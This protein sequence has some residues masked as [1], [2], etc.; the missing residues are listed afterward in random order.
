MLSFLVFLFI[1][2]FLI[3]I[4]EAG[5][6]IIAR[7]NG[8][9]VERFCIG[10]GPQILKKKIKDVE[11]AI[12]LIPLGGYVKLAGENE[13]ESKGYDFEYLSKPI[14]VRA[15]I[16][17]AGPLT[18]YICAF[19]FFSL[20]F[21]VGHQI[22][23]PVV[24]DFLKDSPAKK[25]GI[26]KGD[27]IVE[28]DG[29]KIENWQQL[30]KIVFNCKGKTLSVKVKRDS[31]ILDF[32]IKPTK[33]EYRD[34]LG[35]KRKV[36]FLGIIAKGNTKTKKYPFFRAIFEGA[37]LLFFLTLMIFKALFLMIIRVLPFRE[38][39][40]GPLGIYYLTKKVVHIGL[41]AIFHFIGVL[42][43]S[44]AIF[45]ILP[46]PILDGGHLLFLSLEKIRKK[47]LSPQIEDLIN[48]IA[49]S[50]LIFLVIL[51][52]INDIFRFV[53]K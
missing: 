19:L 49:L 44:L 48:N 5:H 41:G 27:V 18:N 7:R 33:R 39:L 53:I 30:Q 4:H 47:R 6:F 2:S 34:I 3:V 16:V 1:V 52:F 14:N 40:T 45:N 15:K 21:M 10:F 32:K 23:L 8:V 46:F 38:A 29:K 50:L 42:S 20:M 36:Y 22:L 25:A 26:K 28:V 24:G 13:R 31:K 17:L 11:F 12:G 51:V 43:L 35:R 37:K 9:K